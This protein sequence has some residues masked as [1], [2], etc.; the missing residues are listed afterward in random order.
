M[1]ARSFSDLSGCCGPQNRIIFTSG[2][3]PAANSARCQSGMLES[4]KW[5][6][7]VHAQTVGEC[8]QDVVRADSA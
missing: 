5:V 4:E 8:T 6:V 2:I 3:A 7:S 1:S